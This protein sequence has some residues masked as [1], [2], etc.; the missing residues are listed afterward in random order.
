MYKIGVFPGKFMPPHRGHLNSIIN[1]ATKSEL[2]YVVVSDHPK[3]TKRLCDKDGLKIMDL[4]TRAKWLSIELYG[5]DHIKVVMLDETGIEEYPYD[6]TKWSNRLK[7]LIPEE[8]DVIFGGEIEYKE[9][10]KKNFPNAKYEIFDYNIKKYPISA[11]EIRSEPYKNWDYI[12]GSARPFFTKKV[13]IS[14]TESCMKTTISKYLAKIYHTSWTEEEGRYYNEKYLGGNEDV[15]TVEDFER[16]AY[17]QRELEYH[18]LKTANKVTFFDTG[19]LVTQFYL[20]MF[21]NTKSDLIDK[22]IDPNRYDLVLLFKPDVEWVDDGYRRS[23]GIEVREDLH[24]KLKNMYIEYGYGD[25]IIEI[26]GN[27]NERLNQA[28][29]IVDNLLLKDKKEY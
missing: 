15:Y 22:F 29:T 25:K 16:I 3:I 26:S 11:A 21:L 4:K 2:L 19:A 6:W 24:T 18:A 20:D 17:L 28:T 1:A 9:Q 7:K 13:L 8:F 14:G 27:Y 12:L 23:S 10:Y 5:F